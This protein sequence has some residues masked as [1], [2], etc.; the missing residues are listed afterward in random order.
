RQRAGEKMVN[1]LLN[2]NT[3]YG[4]KRKK[5]TKNHKRRKRSKRNED[6]ERVPLVVFGVGIFGKDNERLKKNRCGVTD[7]L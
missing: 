5:H 4:N 6:K 3:K 1:M 7:L 2:R